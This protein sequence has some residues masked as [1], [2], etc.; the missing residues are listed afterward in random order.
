MSREKKQSRLPYVSKGNVLD[1]L[2]FSSKVSAV[3]KMKVELFNKIISIIEKNGY[4]PRTLEK[5][6]DQPQ[7]RVSELLRGKIATV[8]VE[9]LLDYLEKLGG[10]VTIR[11]RFKKAI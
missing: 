6:L 4:A 1:D 7:P 2:G 11:V 10:E 9:K 5:L 8:S 3:V